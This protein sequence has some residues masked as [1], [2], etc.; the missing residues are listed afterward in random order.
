MGSVARY[1]QLVQVAHRLLAGRGATLAVAE[2]L[3]GG[4]LGQRLTA[5]PGAST[6]FRGGVIAYAADIKTSVL[7]VPARLLS[8]RGA[9]D[10]DVALAMAGGV[11]ELLEATYGVGVTGVAGPEPHGGKPPGTFHVA[12]AGPA[13]ERVRSFARSC[14][15]RVRNREDAAESTLEL[16]RS[17]LLEDQPDAPRADP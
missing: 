16:L 7:G 3:T 8:E 9:A 10:P 17:L 4:L 1:E 15:E 5:V 6:T 14:T 12:V 11:R 2:S 13:G